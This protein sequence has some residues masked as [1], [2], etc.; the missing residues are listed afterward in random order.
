MAAAAATSSAAAAVDMEELLREKQ[1]LIVEARRR[2]KV[3][4]QN[5]SKLSQVCVAADQVRQAGQGGAAD[6]SRSHG[7]TDYLVE[8]GEES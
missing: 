4:K 2:K 1:V 8:M 5:F 6:A 3:A 7:A